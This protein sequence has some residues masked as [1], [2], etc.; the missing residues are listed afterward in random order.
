MDA[1]NLLTPWLPS[2]TVVI[3]TLVTAVLYWRGCGRIVVPWYKQLSFWSGLLLLYL[4]LHT[5]LDYYAEREFFIHRAQHMVLHHLGPFFMMLAW[6]GPALRAGLPA[7]WADRF[8]G[9]LT[10]FLP[11]RFA[12]AALCN[13]IITATLFVG[14]IWLWLIPSVHFY[15]M[16]DVDLYRLM[17]WSMTLDG[18]LFWYLVLD[19]RP[20][21]P[22]RLRPGVRV[23]LLVAVIPP[24]I[25]TG[26][27]IT[28]ATHNIYPLYD[29]CGRA[30]AGIDSLTDQTIGGLIL[31]IPSTMMSVVGALI[32]LSFWFRSKDADAQEPKPSTS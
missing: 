21:P 13:P 7:G 4:A 3:A 11:V 15:A 29:L 31:W 22:A 26:A 2:P 24:Q 19:P 17:N 8:S 18:L 20:S 27:L 14:L 25:L 6:P 30:F 9:R 28:F 12:L 23:L 5:R 16:L 10:S 32:A 1:L